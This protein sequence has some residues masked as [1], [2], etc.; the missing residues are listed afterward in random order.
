MDD[1]KKKLNVTFCAIWYHLYKLKNVKN[2][3]VGVLLLVKFLAETC[4]FA[5]SNT[6]PC[7]FF[8]CL[9]L[10]NGTKSPKVSQTKKI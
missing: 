4:N 10:Y 1:M 3:N 8:T 5:K 9:K 7:V 2:T 6:T